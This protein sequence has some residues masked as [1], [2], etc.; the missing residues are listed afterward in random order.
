MSS[1]GSR[2]ATIALLAFCLAP[3]AA[4]AGPAKKPSPAQVSAQR[5]TLPVTVVPNIGDLAYASGA[6]LSPDGKLLATLEGG[7]SAASVRLWDIATGRPLRSLEYFAFF[8]VVLFTP[9]GSSLISAHK[10]GTIKFWNVLSG[11]NTATL[12]ASP[13]KADEDPHAITALWLDEAGELLVAGDDTGTVSVWNVAQRKQLSRF[14]VD[15]DEHIV[16]ARL[17]ADRRTLT[18]ATRY[19]AKT[20]EPPNK[21]TATFTLP[22]DHQFFPD[23]IVGEGG[24][25]VV[26][27]ESCQTEN[28]LYFAPARGPE[29]TSVDQAPQCQKPE[30]DDRIDYDHGEPRVFRV[31]GQSKIIVARYG[32]PA[33]KRWDMATR[34]VE[35]TIAWPQDAS[36]TIIEIG[37]DFR[38][39]VARGPDSMRIHDFAT[40]SLVRELNS[41]KSDA[42]NVVASSNGRH[43]LL[44][45][46]PS[47]KRSGRRDMQLWHV[48]AM[49]PTGAS[50]SAP[51]ETTVYDLAN[52]GKTAVAANDPAEITFFATDSGREQRRLSVAG[53]KEISALRLSPTGK[54]LALLAENEQD[55]R[56]GLLVGADDGKVTLS[57][58]GSGYGNRDRGDKDP[59]YVTSIAFS[60][61]GARFAAGRWN[62]TAEIWSTE[63]VRRLKL[64]PA[65]KK[66]HEQTVS[67]AFSPDGRFLIGGTRD[68]G[69]Y[70][71]NVDSG[72]LVRTLPS[73]AIAGHVNAAAVAVSHDGKLLAA[74]LAERARSSG[75]IGAE[76]RI[77]VWDAATGKLRFNL[78]GHRYGVRAVTFSPEDRWIVSASNDG[79][80][81]YWDRANGRLAV[82]FTALDDGR[83]LMMTQA[84]FFTGSP[85]VEDMINVVRGLEAFP[86]AQL[87]EQLYRPDLVEQLLKGDPAHGYKDAAEKLDLGKLL[88]ARTAP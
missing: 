51:G 11:E 44:V 14:V 83:W 61:D 3:F 63:P 4:H 38:F 16:A 71:W 65:D 66:E 21:V 80:I 45:Q 10:D 29:M 30:G 72:R 62:G 68:G 12:L 23:S 35:T 76:R 28:L 73:E 74:G 69:V 48:D 49:S 20:V 50:F 24:F 70:L 8:S 55:D 36:A 47:Q 81:R 86:A 59:D 77:I 6:V 26:R 41:A 56:V 87:R 52:D 15:T 32:I 79:T 85:G 37:R 34:S 42:D 18:A 43:V 75:D 2:A 40:G 82:T 13:H 7:S 54:F 19:L 1:I 88:P 39:A 53:V 25:I 57:L 58:T 5:A 84:G 64:L 9:D 60:P 46:P 22:R 27:F 78:R 17:S 33:L 67:L 31:P